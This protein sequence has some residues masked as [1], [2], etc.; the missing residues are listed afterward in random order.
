MSD[1]SAPDVANP[2]A[3][4]LWQLE[5]GIDLPLGEVI[6]QPEATRQLEKT[7]AA[8]AVSVGGVVPA[9]A[10]A[11]V[12]VVNLT[13]GA[14]RAEAVRLAMAAQTLDDLRAAING[15]GGIDIKRHATKLV[16][17]DGH[18]AARI[19]VV[20]DAPGAD[21]DVTGLPFAGDEG[22]LLD[23][24][25]AAI[26]LSRAA[27]DAAQAVYIS[28]ILNWRPPGNRSPT[29]TEIDLSLPFIER[30]IQLVAPR[31]LILSGAVAAKALLG[32]AEGTTK[33]RGKWAM[34]QAVS[35]PVDAGLPPIPAMPLYHPAFLLNTPAK[36]R[37][38]WADLQLVQERF[39]A[40]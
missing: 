38:A 3:A 36:K 33:L 23:R 32:S 5:H 34:Y 12:P 27:A 28:N 20:G 4:L 17:A 25:L 21:E 35:L 29:P 16:F 39:A 7:V 11:P 2:R 31:L 13:D 26:G 37:E 30:H 8:D 1:L 40:L 15:F 19:M 22:A 10:A 18:P 6:W 24:M 9:V 14:L